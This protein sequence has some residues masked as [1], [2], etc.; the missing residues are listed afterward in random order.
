MGLDLFQ[1]VVFGFFQQKEGEQKIED[2]KSE[3]MKN[4]SAQPKRATKGRKIPA[5]IVEAS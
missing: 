2:G 5:R 1:G 3:K 4:M